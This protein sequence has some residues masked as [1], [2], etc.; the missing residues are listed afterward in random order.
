MKPI[1]V[2]SWIELFGVIVGTILILI[3]DTLFSVWLWGVIAVGIFGLPALGFWQI[4]GLKVLISFLTG[5]SILP[6]IKINMIG[7]DE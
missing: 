6:S 4:I 7:G 2:T 1:E 5:K 3:A